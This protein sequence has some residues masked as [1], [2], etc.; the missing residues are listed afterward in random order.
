MWDHDST[1]DDSDNN[2]PK[3]DDHRSLPAWTGMSSHPHE[4]EAESAVFRHDVLQ[5]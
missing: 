3:I 4:E 1:Y 5:K 2:L